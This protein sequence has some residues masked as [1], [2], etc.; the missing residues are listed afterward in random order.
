MLLIK[1]QNVNRLLIGFSTMDN[2]FVFNAIVER[3]LSRKVGTFDVT[4]IVF[5]KDLETIQQVKVCVR[6]SNNMSI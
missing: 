5:S 4:F 3:N 2:C 1:Y 6:S